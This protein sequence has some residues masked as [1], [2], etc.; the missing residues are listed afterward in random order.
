MSSG[1]E[2]P[3]RRGDRGFVLRLLG[4]G[5]AIVA[6]AVVLLDVLDSTDFGGCA[7]RGFEE[8]TETRPSD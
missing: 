7:A 4:G 5:L 8:V 2:R 6:I 3:I 1:D